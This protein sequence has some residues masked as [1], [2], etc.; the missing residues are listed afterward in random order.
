[1]RSRLI[2]GAL[3]IVP[4]VVASAQRA[5]VI[6]ATGIRE[7]RAEFL[8][9]P[10]AIAWV[11]ATSEG[12]VELAFDE[13]LSRGDVSIEPHAAREFFAPNEVLAWV[14]GVDSLIRDHGRSSSESS[15]RS[16]TLGRVGAGVA[17]EASDHGVLRFVTQRCGVPTQETYV[18][19]QLML[20]TAAAL[21][22]AALDA[23][24]VA[25]RS[26]PT[27]A[28]WFEHAV[29]CGAQAK[30]GNP[31]PVWPMEAAVPRYPRQVLVQ[32]VVSPTGN[33][34]RGSERFLSST[35]PRFAAAIRQVLPAWRYRPATRMGLPVR[36]LV[37]ASIDFSPPVVLNR[38]RER[39]PPLRGNRFGDATCDSLFT[40]TTGSDAV[41]IVPQG[42]GAIRIANGLED[43]F[44]FPTADRFQTRVAIPAT[45]FR[46][47]VDTV[48]RLLPA[49]AVSQTA[50]ALANSEYAPGAPQIGTENGLGLHMWLS[51]TGWIRAGYGCGRDGEGEIR[52]MEIGPH[53][54][55][56]FQ[57]IAR[58]ALVRV[59]AQPPWSEQR[60]R[61][62]AE[63]EL[64]CAVS[65]AQPESQPL[66]LGPAQQQRS[67]EVLVRFVVDTSGGVDP[68][69]VEI[70]PGPDSTSSYLTIDAVEHW[71]FT[72][73]VAEGIHVRARVH[74]SVVIR[75]RD[76]DAV[77]LGAR[78]FVAN[79]EDTLRRTVFYKSK[80]PTDH[81]QTVRSAEAWGSA[82]RAM[83]PYVDS[84][85]RTWPAARDRF[86]HG[87]PLGHRLFVTARISDAL[88][89]VE[90]VFILVERIADG[91]IEGRIQS[92]VNLLSSWRRGDQF[93]LAESE[94]ID[95]TV[96]RPDG[97]EEGNVVGT[98]LDTYWQRRPK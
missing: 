51:S 88:D 54:F 10:F 52:F 27:D 16:R 47:F 92:D 78:P 94:L 58:E 29:S 83:Q 50:H 79:P 26:V 15:V 95:W 8:P 30:E 1:M 20:A 57:H 77:A 87:L 6:Q 21:R 62:Y 13:R 36:Q 75:P 23:A 66:P 85:R 84:A 71:R 89:R 31:P 86:V 65:R 5:P 68:A 43:R 90:Q 70:M 32:F 9:P 38:T 46:Q 67:T 3:A 61:V 37:H 60:N 40:L 97:T 12:L 44:D 35:D 24:A 34:E 80:A 81:P 72:P 69:S 74:A 82:S 63:H 7:R 14:A 11:A 33:V 59:R 49:M 53:E 42:N 18:D 28:V 25:P 56:M 41:S 55:D 22:R 45:L 4:G 93:S 17:F 39:C 48:A 91:R 64:T 19:P 73:A 96:V 76:A 2:A 98:F